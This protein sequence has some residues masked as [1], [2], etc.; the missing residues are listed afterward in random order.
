MI[1]L[2]NI[3]VRF[4]NG[5]ETVHVLQDLSLKIDEGDAVTVIGSNGAGKST[6]I[7]LLSGEILPHSGSIEIDGINITKWSQLKRAKLIAKVFQNPNIGTFA[8]LTVEEN[9]LVA[10][11][12]GARRNLKYAY[13]KDTHTKFQKILSHIGIGLESRMHHKVS[14]LSGGQKQAL[15]IVMA[16]LSASKVLLLDEHTAAL[17]PK[18]TRTIMRITKDIVEESRLTT[19]MITHSMHYALEFGNRTLVLSGGKVVR[20]IRDKER[21]STSEADLLKCFDV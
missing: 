15:S 7:N 1:H 9:M 2:K 11:K 21:K 17:D 12:R 4:R 6:L 10:L 8:D 13:S 3:N 5:N 14:V 19:I 20:D 16:T 18:T